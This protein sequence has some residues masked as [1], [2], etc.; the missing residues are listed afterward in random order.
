MK[1]T[2][3][4]VSCLLVVA[5]L[6]VANANSNSH[7]LRAEENGASVQDETGTSQTPEVQE[8]SEEAKNEN[9]SDEQDEG[10]PAN[11]EETTGEGQSDESS[12]NV[13]EST[14]SVPA[15]P[16]EETVPQDKNEPA[17][18]SDSKAITNIGQVDVYIL[19]SLQLKQDTVFNVSLSSQ[20][21]KSIT[22][23]ADHSDVLR[24]GVTFENLAAGTYTLNVTAPGFASYT[25]QIEVANW[26][27]T[28]KLTTGTVAG[29]DYANDKH[30]GILLIGDVNRDTKIDD[31]DKD[32]MIDSLEGKGD[33]S[34]ADL[35]KDKKVSLV[36]LEY[37]TR[38]YK[39]EE[40]P[41]STVET[42]VPA[43]ALETKSDNG[44]KV[45]GDLYHLSTSESHVTLSRV[46]GQDI[47]VSTP[48][49]VDFEFPDNTQ[50]LPEGM[51]IGA[52]KDNN[53][54]DAVVTINYMEN[55]KEETAEVPFGDDIHFLMESQNVQVKQ[56]GS[57]TICIDFGS[58]IAI[59]KVTLKI[60]GAKN[61]NLAEISR[62]EFL[63]D[64]EERIGEPQMSIPQNLEVK[65]GNKE[66]TVTWEPCL[67]VTGYEVMIENGGIQE[68]VNVKGS[69]ISVKS[70]ANDEL[71]NK[72]N[73]VVK[74]QS[75]NGAWR[76]GYSDP[77]TATPKATSK[78]DAPDYVKG[79]GKYKAI[80]VSWKDMEDTDYYNLYYKEADAATYQKVTNIKTNSYVLGELKDKKAYLIYV[81]GV[82]ELGES[83]PSL[84]IKVE[85]TD[86][87]PAQMPKHKLL[88]RADEGKVSE[89]ITNVTFNNGSMKD[90]PLDTAGKT[91]WGTVDNNPG[92]YFYLGSW[93]SGGYNPLGNNG[94]TFE[95]DQAY[96]MQMFSFQEVSV[97]N[98][99]YAYIRV[100]Y[101]DENG[102]ATEISR[103]AM[104]LQQRRDKDG[105][106]YYMARMPQPIKA[107]KIQFGI[108]RSL[109]SDTITI[110]EVYFYHY[111]SIEADIMALYEDDLHTVLR[112]DVT[113]Q[114][115][116]DLRTRINTKDPDCDEYHPDKEI[117]ERELKTAEDILNSVLTA[118]VQVH[119]TITTKD[120]GRGFGGL[121]AWQPLGV[122]VPAGEQI[123]VYVGH[124]TKKTGASTNLQ[125]VATQYH[126]EATTMFKVIANLKVGRNDITIPRLASTNVESGGALYVQYTGNS[127]NDKYAV[128]VS[129]GSAVPILDLYQVSDESERLARVKTYLQSLD[130][131]IGTIESEHDKLH[132][133][134]DNKLVQYEFDNQNCILGAS[135]IML[136]TMMLSLPAQ[137]IVAGSGSGTIDQRAQKVLN[138]MDAIE[139]M[140]HLFYQHK[141]LNNNASAAIDKIPVAHLNIRYQRMF[142]GAF[143]YASGNHIGIE[144]GSTSGMM[145][146]V[147]VQS[148]ADGRYVSGQYFGWGIA[149]EIGH[150][151]NQGSYAIAEITNNYFSV[152]AQAKDTNNSVRFQYRNVYDKVTS[153]TK[154]RSSNV[155]TQLGLYWQLHLAYDN[156]YNYK[157]YADHNDQLA[158]LF[159]ARVD[160][161]SR[162]PSKAPKPNGIALTPGSDVDQTLMRL[163]CAAAEK[164]IL[165]YFERWGMTPDEGTIA[166]AKQFPKETR[167]IY[168]ASDDARV[169]RLTNS[170]SILGTEGKV[171][172]VGSSTSAAINGSNANQVDFTLSATIPA[173]DVLGYE[174]VRCTTSNGEVEK[175][176][177][178]FATENTFSDHITTMNNRVV[179]YEVTVIDKYLNRSAVKTLAPLKI[180]HDGSIDK[181]F[182]S[183]TTN[184][185]EATNVAESGSGDEN[186]P[187][188]PQLDAPIVKAIDND[189]T[190]TYTGTAKSG[191]E[192]ILEFN[193]THSVTGFKYTVTT[194]TP[195]TDYEIYV[196]DTD[197]SWL[198]AASG[199]FNSNS[200]QTVYFGKDGI[201]N[202]AIYKT[203]AVKFVIKAP[204]NTEI[205][206]SELDVLSVTGDN[207]DFRRTGEGTVA[208]G[209]LTADYKYGKNEDDVIPKDSIIFTGAY[210]GNPAYNVVI[211]YDQDGNIVGGIDSDGALKAYQTI[212]A[213]VPTT[214]N[215]QD[216]NDG[217]W[218][219]WLDPGTDISALKQVRAELYRVDNALTNEGQRLV[220]DSLFETVPTT[221]PD[222][223][224]GN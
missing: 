194:G 47:S 192:V 150:C 186:T 114:T 221:L 134:S 188:G 182:W 51:I 154:G 159:F 53:I 27:Y 207:V 158:N 163:S 162:T 111:D 71:V 148:D 69:M 128:R 5:L 18:G 39:V 110:S 138:S 73:Y 74:V 140:M 4:I 136:D 206:I 70:F 62:V 56:E 83:K 77:I 24:E 133:N 102:V 72:E 165:E 35:N 183:A 90:S 32:L 113:Q 171:E 174:I 31:V 121:N 93:D 16:T 127:A 2:K 29:Y 153:N 137:Q 120:V 175:E 210:K 181:S 19:P 115:I 25:Q 176:I 117:L 219:Y 14:P 170:G 190:T 80:N 99:A 60:L 94:V 202:V 91:A 95:F 116:D 178:G 200:V 147:P 11:P 34:Q 209:K 65:N 142:A 164:N 76:S 118:P 63:N 1:A 98:L 104:S 220:S 144:W 168:Y 21:D 101:W 172:A 15:A 143:M 130:T 208:I 59:K 84:T 109:A 222:I 88:N 223:Q 85:T 82:N 45:V 41:V 216:V 12:N 58:Q 166:Y 46:D 135:D 9:A 132:K 48:V 214:G 196:R 212:L 44:T 42:S 156:G 215:I 193:R 107:K 92:S 97:Q 61:N 180:E 10:T 204:T 54:T 213:D 146:G 38:G 87:S 22:L 189:S 211:L 187:C 37:F 26:A 123:T 218:I 155:F 81:T 198:E 96:E 28:V 131:Y 201:D 126:A 161:Y 50:F 8:G 141:G 33:E 160:T 106:I 149:H 203:S 179:T 55:G 145:G 139:D 197:G 169:Y 7:I 17:A 3:R 125:L 79:V 108:A 157:T 224:L 67:N 177:A 20:A 103:D 49:S 75:V 100:R 199:T 78:P 86:I 184:N 30:P 57:G 40:D 89:H 195:I 52:G 173:N 122:S 217:T 124:N 43:K 6:L 191:A 105:R 36:D 112:S 152:L 205:A 119:N 64:M 151:I 68:T 167:A 129:G 185:I 13:D 66:F 23:K